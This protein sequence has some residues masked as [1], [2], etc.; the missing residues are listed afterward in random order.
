MEDMTK[1]VPMKTFVRSWK[2]FRAHANEAE[3]ISKSLESC[4]LWKTPQDNVIVDIG[5]GD[6]QVLKEIISRTASA[7]T[8]I[9]CTLV[10]PMESFIEEARANIENLPQVV[11]TT[12]L[13][14]YLKDNYKKIPKKLDTVFFIHTAYVVT[15]EDWKLVLELSER[16]ASII[17]VM[18]DP[19]SIFTHCWSITAP[20]FYDRLQEAH[21]FI[22]SLIYNKQFRV[23]IKNATVL[24]KN[25]FDF[26]KS[27]AD[28]ILSLICYTDYA[29]LPKYE[30]LTIQRFVEDRLTKKGLPCD[31]SIFKITSHHNRD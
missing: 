1:W 15:P 4:K 2:T 16:G 6:G 7:K 14:G 19:K 20:K 11:S 30:R 8:R 22:D 12:S 17:W 23:D 18:D 5:C 3:T 27:V 28:K 13:L 9:E 24:A 29:C 25:P 26:P 10:D 31:I 21:Q